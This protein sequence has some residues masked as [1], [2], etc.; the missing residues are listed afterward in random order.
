[1]NNPISIGIIGAGRIGLT[2]AKS[3][4]NDI[5]GVNVKTVSDPYISKKAVEE[6]NAL[7]IKN[8]NSDYRDVLSDPEIE[9]VIICSPTDTHSLI[10][11]EAA[12]KKKHVF[13]EK[14]IDLDIDKIHETLLIV[15]QSGI[16][17][18]VGFNHRFDHNF[19]AV[20]KHIIKGNIG[21]VHVV[22]VTSRDPSPPGIEYIKSSGG[23]FTDM[24]IHDFDIVRFL[25]GVEVVEVYAMGSV[26]FDEEIG[27]AGDFDTAT[28]ALKLENDAIA[29]IDI[30]RRAVYGYDQRVEVFGSGGSVNISNDTNSTA[31]LSNGQGVIGEKPKYFFLERYMD[32]FAEEKKEFFRAIKNNT[33]PPV[34][35][36]DGFMSVVI[37][38]A[39][40]KSVREKR[41]VKIKE[42]IDEYSKS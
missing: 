19:K 20:K 16:K 21:K 17:Y 9:A 29:L 15:E 37:A 23:I 2:H 30:S 6:L 40:N 13:C 28:A 14:P 33:D 36:Y 31:L 41:P 18:Q 42:I 10:S 24:M 8:I 39:A 38:E 1:M 22:K 32:A 12:K 3:I 25:S 26:C 5:P 34:T 11:I 4:V 7:G 27:K 35:G